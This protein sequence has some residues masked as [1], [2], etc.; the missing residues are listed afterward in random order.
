MND[1][2]LRHP[3][4][5]LLYRYLNRLFDMTAA[6]LLLLVSFPVIALMVVLV[7][8]TSKGP[9]FFRQPRVGLNGEVFTMIKLRTMRIDAEAGGF[10]W[11]KPGDSRITPIGRFLRATHLDELPQL[12]NVLLGQMSLVGP[13]PE[14]PEIVELLEQAIPDYR[15]RLLVR[16]GITGLAQINLPPDTDGNSVR[17]KQLLDLDYIEN[18]NSWLDLRILAA[19]FLRLFGLKGGMGVWMLG[20][21]RKPVLAGDEPNFQIEKQRLV[22]D[23]R[24]ESDRLNSKTA[25]KPRG[26]LNT[27]RVGPLAEK[28]LPN[29]RTTPAMTLTLAASTREKVKSK[30]LMSNSKPR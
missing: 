6:A 17:R 28:P 16:P 5:N 8:L 18:R 29:P 21:K 25:S 7:R 2:S 12:Y 22:W 24:R 15:Q 4:S 20:L 1:K 23:E 11:S 27:A 13:R 26:E 19:T 30:N 14:R 10:M 3:R 9:G